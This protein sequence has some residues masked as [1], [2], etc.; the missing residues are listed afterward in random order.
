MSDVQTGVLASNYAVE[1]AFML[2]DGVR[3][4]WLVLWMRRLK[5]ANGNNERR[6]EAGL[7]RNLSAVRMLGNER[8]GRRGSTT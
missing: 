5:R 2:R 7:V 6:K 1:D 3:R 8:R 4:W